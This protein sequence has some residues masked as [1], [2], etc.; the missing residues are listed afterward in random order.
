VTTTSATSASSLSLTSLF[1]TTSGGNATNIMSVL[2]ATAQDAA[3]AIAQQRFTQVQTLLQNQYSKKVA[4]LQAQSQPTAVEN[5]LQVQ[6]SN[7]GKQKSTF[8][9]LE[10][11]YANNSAILADLT[12]FL[13]TLQ[14]AAQSGD[15]AAFDGAL[16]NA[17]A[18]VSYLTVVAGNPALQDDGVGQLNANGLGIKSSSSYDLST[19]SGQAAAIA[20]INAAQANITQISVLTN[21][22]Q[23][24]AASQLTAL[25][26]QYDQLNNQ[27]QND[28]FD[29]QTQATTQILNLKN[30][31]NTQLHLVELQF[32][33]TQ[34]AAKS[35]E[36]QQNNLQAVLSAPAPGTIFAIFA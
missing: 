6:I 10:T 24:I 5:F 36:N 16:A 11:Q 31:L 20:D 29:Q 32:S 9:T 26:S 34:A 22:N 13:T 15:S 4:A 17:N 25:G 21:L 3:T 2:T 14:N 7:L 28:Q 33:N 12:T 1:N 23:N 27:L 30:Q 8:S 19:A 18:D 35:L